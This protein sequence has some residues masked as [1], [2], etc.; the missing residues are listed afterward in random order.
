MRDRAAATQ[1]PGW[2]RDPSR[3]R[4]G[5]S[6]HHSFGAALRAARRT[7]GLTQAELAGRLGTT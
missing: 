6:A 5:S 7:A 2:D 3:A 4:G 1:E